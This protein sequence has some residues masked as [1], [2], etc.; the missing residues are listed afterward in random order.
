MTM[1]D[2]TSVRQEVEEKA[3]Y[4]HRVAV[5]LLATSFITFLIVTGYRVVSTLAG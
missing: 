3:E 5:N 1:V 4:R 2:L